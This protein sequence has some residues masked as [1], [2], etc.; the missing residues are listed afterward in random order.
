MTPPT[1]DAVRAR[2]AEPGTALVLETRLDLPSGRSIECQDAEAGGELVTIRNRD[3]Q[4][5]LEVRLTEAG[6]VL[7]FDA[8]Q[9]ELRSA[10][11]IRAVCDRFEVEAARGVGLRSVRGDVTVQA[12][13]YVRLNAE[14]IK[15]NCDL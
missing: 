1:R 11:T 10:G 14:L 8:A 3:G 2:P 13:D 5:E 6:P 12:S 7:R 9:L 4:V 15:L